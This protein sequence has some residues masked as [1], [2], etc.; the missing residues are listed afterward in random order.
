MNDI[1]NEG[2]K[3]NLSKEEKWGVEYVERT[4]KSGGP[5]ESLARELLKEHKNTIHVDADLHQMCDIPVIV[6]TLIN[7][8]GLIALW[9]V[10]LVLM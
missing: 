6:G 3:K 5:A 2:M 10:V 9:I 8:I 4:E 7:N 1:L